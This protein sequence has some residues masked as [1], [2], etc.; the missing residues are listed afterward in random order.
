MIPF[1]LVGTV[2]SVI[3]NGFTL[4][5]VPF[6]LLYAVLAFVAFALFLAVLTLFADGKWP[7]EKD[8]GFY[9]FFATVA[10]FVIAGVLNIKVE[11]E[12]LDLIPKER[13]LMVQNHR[14][15]LDPVICL[16]ALNGYQIGFITKPENMK[17][18]IVGKMMLKICSL[19]ID[20]DNPRNAVK[21]I[22]A[23]AAYIEN[24]ICSIV[25]YPEGTRSKTE[26]RLLPFRNG[27]FKIATKSG[28]PVVVSSIS[29]N[30]G[31]KWNPF[32]LTTARVGILDIIP[33]GE[34]R[35]AK[36]D[37][38]SDR[39]RKDILDGLGITEEESE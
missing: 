8:S 23:A 35:G 21:T 15:L 10:A 36:T 32:S 33:G 29:F 13:F 31:N 18:P 39:C 37:A 1:I 14:S 22:N 2:F 5:A 3:K 28:A 34:T 30:G 19:P 7:A 25:V 27:A 24:D 26:G 12:G 17:L 16:V 6:A 4:I 38:L 20:R 11:A 9:R